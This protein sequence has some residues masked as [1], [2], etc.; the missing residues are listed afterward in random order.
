[1]GNDDQQGMAGAAA[2]DVSAG[3][4]VSGVGGQELGTE[5][6]A[7]DEGIGGIDDIVEQGRRTAWG[8]DEPAFD[9]QTDDER[10]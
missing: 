1:M 8:R 10:A 9:N 2:D 7:A 5:A 6:G 3:V 4:S